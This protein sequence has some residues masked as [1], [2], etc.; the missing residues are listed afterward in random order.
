VPRWLVVLAIGVA[1]GATGLV[2][3]QER[4]LP[5][6]LSAS[7]STALRLSAERLGLERTRLDAELAQTSQRLQAVLADQRRQADELAASRAT[8]E[9]LRADIAAVVASL[10][11]DPRQGGVEVRAGRFTARD[12]MLAYDVVI[13]RAR[14]AG[15]ATGG[16]MQLV[17]AG[18]NA[19][20]TATTVTLKSIA[21][22]M[23]SH[24]VVRGSLPLP[25]GFRPRQTTIQVL[26]RLA[27]KALGMRVLPVG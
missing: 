27:G 4:F 18:E 13:T 2:V 24:E 17:V 6:R 19:S 20:G 10:P 9:R 8:V 11:P 1:V 21:L 12:G 5:Q 25:E 14:G 7:E 26:D 16:V 23:G 22:S 15:R 3:V